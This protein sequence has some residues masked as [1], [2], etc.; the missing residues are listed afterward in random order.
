MFWYVVYTKPKNEKKVAKQLK[1]LG[2]EVYCPLVNTIKQWSDRKKKVE[3]PLITSYVFVKI[4]E[5]KRD[6]VFQAPGVVRYLF[7]LGKPAKVRNVEIEALKNNLNNSQDVRVE[8]LNKGEVYSLNYGPFK[9]E[10]GIVHE[11]GKNRIQI[12]L[13]ELGIKVTIKQDELSQN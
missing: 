3:I 5:P 10:K 4:E 1:E 6:L 8:G 7:Y 12:L 13:K 9:G 2:I 11:V